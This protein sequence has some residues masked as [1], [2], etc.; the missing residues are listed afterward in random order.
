MFVDVM[1]RSLVRILSCFGVSYPSSTMGS[2]KMHT[3]ID[4]GYGSKD[5]VCMNNN[6][7][8]RVD[9][10]KASYLNANARPNL[11]LPR[12][13]ALHQ[14]ILCNLRLGYLTAAFYPESVIKN[15]HLEIDISVP[16]VPFG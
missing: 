2:L 14:T 10:S 7:V 1:G 12:R 11:V 13:S 15:G 16:T 4:A 9:C 5:V 6:V 3:P 8:L